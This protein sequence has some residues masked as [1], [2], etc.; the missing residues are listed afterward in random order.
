MQ[1]FEGLKGGHAIFWSRR[2]KEFNTVVY[3]KIKAE[4]LVVNW[5]NGRV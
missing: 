5:D 4:G 3:K 1:A 2:K